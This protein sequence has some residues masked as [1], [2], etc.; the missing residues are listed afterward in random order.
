MVVSDKSPKSASTALLLCIFLGGL[1]IHRFYVGKLGTGFLMLIT[2]GGL[3]IWTL[4]DIITISI[5]EFKDRDGKTLEFTKVTDNPTKHIL[6]V[7]GLILLGF[8]IFVAL[9]LRIAFLATSGIVDVATGQLTALRN[10][11]MV[12]AYSYTSKEFQKADSL[13]DFQKFLDAHPALLKN[14]SVSFDSRS[15]ENKQ[16]V[17]IGKLY[18]KGGVATP[19]KYYLVKEN[20][21]WKVQAVVVDS[22]DNKQKETATETSPTSNND[23]PLTSLYSDKNKLFTVKYPADWQYDR[24]KNGITLSGMKN[25]PYF[26]TTV[27]IQVIPSNKLGGQYKTVDD[28]INDMKV[29]IS[30]QT[31][32]AQLL[33][34]G[35]VTF[36]QEDKV[37]HGRFISYTYIYHKQ[38]MKL[39]QVV[40]YNNDNSR[41]YSWTYATLESQYSLGLPIVKAMYN[42]WLIGK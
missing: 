29:Q 23:I 33:N 6:K 28:F 32:N 37:Y 24:S 20:G 8:L 7:L 25:T 4:V 10:G 31:S 36:P 14:E 13:D 15:I 42:A 39:M 41:F 35:D 11:D 16:G 5:C 34:E 3:G 9:I 22:D 19:I 21:V 38:P 40:I 26:Y 12:L 30:K 27:N 2:A 18:S 1:G 17:L